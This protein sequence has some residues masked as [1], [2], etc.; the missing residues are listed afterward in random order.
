MNIG[1]VGSGYTPFGGREAALVEISRGLREHGHDVT[2]FVPRAVVSDADKGIRVVEIPVAGHHGKKAWRFFDRQVSERR[3]ALGLDVIESFDRTNCQDVYWAGEG[4]HAQ[5]LSIRRDG[6]LPWKRLSFQISPRHRGMLCLERQTLFAPGSRVITISK[7]G[8]REIQS[9]YGLPD[10]A[11]RVIYMG[12]DTDYYMP[13]KARASR[14]RIRFENNVEVRDVVI[15]F[16]GRDYWRKG[17]DYLIRGIGSLSTCRRKHTI[18]WVL[19]RGYQKY[20]RRLAAHCDL[21]RLQF[22]DR[23]PDTR[24]LYGGADAF[25]MPSTYEGFGRVYL[26]ASACGLPVL[27]GGKHTGAAEIY[28]HGQDSL[29]VNNVKNRYSLASAIELWFD[30]EFRVSMG[31]AGRSLAKRFPIRRNI[32]DTEKALKDIAD[33]N[34]KVQL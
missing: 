31:E 8:K 9:H 34:W 4:C 29:I 20:Y 5:W 23:V 25:A 27:M 1:L 19:G 15:L 16:V 33:G 18:L 3:R 13:K 14:D 28:T 10:N 2:V 32:R 30:T 11:F 12:V 24:M 7:L 6:H 21:K 22:F 17:L 26:E